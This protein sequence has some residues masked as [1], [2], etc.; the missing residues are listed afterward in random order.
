MHGREYWDWMGHRHGRRGGRERPQ[1]GEWLDEPSVRADRGVVRYLVLDAIS[2]RARHGYEIMQVIE[3]RSHG[4]YRPSPGIVYPTLQMLEEVGHASLEGGE[5]KSYA[6][7]AAG[8]EDLAAH[9]IDVDEF[10][11]RT[12][13]ELGWESYATAFA[14]LGERVKRLFKLY[15]RAAMRGRLTPQVLRRVQGALD[16]AIQKIEDALD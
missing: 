3:E 9:K 15:K 4:S 12:E 11:D 14:M 16:E 8:K 13:G 7:T 1:W 10:Y 2:D 5:R 6:I